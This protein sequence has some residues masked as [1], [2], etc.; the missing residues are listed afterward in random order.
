MK[1]ITFRLQDDMYEDLK[2]Y[3]KYW[4]IKPSEAVRL[5]IQAEISKWILETPCRELAD[6]Y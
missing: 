6:Y 3:C 4:K 2:A 5:C 1:K